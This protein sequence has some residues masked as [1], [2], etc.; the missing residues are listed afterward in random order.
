MITLKSESNNKIYF[1]NI[2][3]ISVLKE[4]IRE[5][6]DCFNIFMC[7]CG[8]SWNPCVYY[9][10]IYSFITYLHTDRKQELINGDIQKINS[11][12][13]WSELKFDIQ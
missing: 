9:G 1:C 2:K 10:N 4:R 5:G 11:G 8:G 3:S 12:L 6:Q 13:S 7:Y